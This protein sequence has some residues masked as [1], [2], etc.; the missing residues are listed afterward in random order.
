LELRNDVENQ[1]ADLQNVENAEIDVFIL[2]SGRKGN[3]AISQEEVSVRFSE[4]PFHIWLW[5]M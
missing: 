2:I 1:V 4:I 3:P 5:W